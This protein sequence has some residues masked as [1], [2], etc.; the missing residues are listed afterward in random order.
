MFLKAA[1]SIALLLV[2]HG[3]FTV[4]ML[5]PDDGRRIA[6]MQQ[7]TGQMPLGLPF[8][9]PK[10]DRELFARQRADVSLEEAY[11]HCEWLMPQLFG[12]CK[13][14]IAK[15]KKRAVKSLIRRSTGVLD[16][17][18]RST[19]RQAIYAAI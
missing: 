11:R 10:G 8:H 6:S 2:L 19:V 16:V 13:R 4:T 3:G 12:W 7:Q 18:R 1:A 9:M 15:M 17:L 5:P 14:R